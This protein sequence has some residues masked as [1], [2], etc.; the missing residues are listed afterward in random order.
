[1]RKL[2]Y[3]VLSMFRSGVSVTP[4]GIK[5]IADH[6]DLVMRLK[7]NDRPEMHY[8]LL[9]PHG[10]ARAKFQGVFRLFPVHLVL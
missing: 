9:G 3:L 6:Y 7:A 5:A 4:A 2:K 10:G 1:M 8:P